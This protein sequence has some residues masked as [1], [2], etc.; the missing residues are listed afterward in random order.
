MQGEQHQEEKFVERSD[1]R[2]E[3]E[4]HKVTTEPSTPVS[5][6]HRL[7]E[8]KLDKQFTKFMEVFK[9]LKI[10]IQFAEALE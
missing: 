9:K 6:P 1:E 3:T 4:K 5:Y 8:N 10:N 7:R 2:K